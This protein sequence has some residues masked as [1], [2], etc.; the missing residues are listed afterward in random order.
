MA[1]FRSPVFNASE[2]FVRAQAA[3]LERYQPLVV[4]L[5]DKGHVPDALAGR[6]LLAEGGLERLRVRLGRWGRL[7][8]RVREAAPALVHAHFGPDGVLAL[9][10]A[11]ALGVPLVTTLRG[12]DVSRRGLLGS[13]R[14][15]W[16]RYALGRGRLMREGDL[17]LTVCESLR[18]AGAGAGLPGGTD[19]GSL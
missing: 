14:L 17:F 10:L 16:M 19:A 7:G 1:V 4:G 12:Y 18:A 9:P 13:G 5:E 2:T 11:R 6:V 8:E 3:G 15:S